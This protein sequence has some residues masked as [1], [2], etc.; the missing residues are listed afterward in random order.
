MSLTA[1]VLV[2]MILALSPVLDYER[3]RLP[4]P[5]S[6]RVARV[7]ATAALETT[8]PIETTAFLFVVGAHES[9]Y[10][11]SL[12][13]DRGA[14]CGWL[15]TPCAQTPGFRVCTDEER[16]DPKLCTK[17]RHFTSSPTR[18]LEQARVAIRIWNDAASQC[19]EHPMWMYASGTCAS[20]ATGLKY[21]EDPKGSPAIVS[22]TRELMSLYARQFSAGAP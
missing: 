9:A 7:I 8:T 11:P 20:S 14:S 22:V 16:E 1:Q 5:C 19:P 2:P 12:V 13:G 10:N 15:Q 6:E 17:G 3:V 21:E 18:A 4:I